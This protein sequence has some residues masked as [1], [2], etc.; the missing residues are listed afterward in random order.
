MFTLNDNKEYEAE[1]GGITFVCEAPDKNLEETAAEI[2]RIYESKL[3]S[4]AEFMIEEGICDCYGEL[5]SEKIISSLGKPVIYL[6][7]C[8]ITY[9]EHTLDDIHIFDV[10]Y[11]GL[12]D[13]F[14]YFSING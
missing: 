5:T 4:I 8:V 1:I 13:E 12:L 7:R 3:N 9:L 10:E 11:G 6:E 2:A 14:F